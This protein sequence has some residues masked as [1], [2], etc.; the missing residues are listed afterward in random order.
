MAVTAGR[1]LHILGGKKMETVVLHLAEVRMVFLAE[2]NPVSSPSAQHPLVPF[3]NS[4]NAW[5]A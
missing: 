5:S 4:G 1:G 2:T 3:P